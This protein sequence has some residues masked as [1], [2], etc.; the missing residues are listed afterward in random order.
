VTDDQIRTYLR[1]EDTKNLIVENNFNIND[2]PSFLLL[3]QKHKPKLVVIDSLRSTHRG[4]GVSENDSEFALPLRW[5]EQMMGQPGMFEQCMILVIHHSGH[6]RAGARGTSALGDMTSFGM[7]FETPGEK[8]GKNPVNQRIL[9]FTKHRF[10]MQGHQIVCTLGGDSTVRLHYIGANA[11]EKAATVQDR[12]R[13]KLQRHPEQDFTLDDLA[14]DAVICGSEDACKKA[15]QRLIRLGQCEKRGSR[16]SPSGKRPRTLYGSKG[17]SPLRGVSKG[18]YI[19]VSDVPKCSK[20]PGTTE[21]NEGTG[22]CPEMDLSLNQIRKINDAA[23]NEFDLD[24]PT[25]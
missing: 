3:A 8:S 20:P 25:S 11:S 2:Y 22:G 17:V 16:P 12:I 5:Y 19:S 10:G 15:V 7:N 6:G 13:L 4:T 9:T 1:R 18:S 23:W 21:E 14:N 24:V